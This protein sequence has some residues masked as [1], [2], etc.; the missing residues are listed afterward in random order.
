MFYT[1]DDAGVPQTWVEMMRRSISLAER[2]SAQRMM[3]EY[4]TEFYF[5][6]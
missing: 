6:D 2:F 3:N 1:R 4:K 5:K